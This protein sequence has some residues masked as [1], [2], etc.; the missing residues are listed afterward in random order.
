MA[1]LSK[2]WR[3]KKSPV[4]SADE[5]EELVFNNEPNAQDE[6]VAEEGEREIVSRPADRQDGASTPN[7]GFGGFASCHSSNDENELPRDLS[8]I[9]FPAG[10]DAVSQVR[11]HISAQKLEVL[12]SVHAL[13]F[14]R[15][16]N[17][18]YAPIRLWLGDVLLEHESMGSFWAC[19]NAY[20]NGHAESDVTLYFHAHH[21]T[22][23]G[24]KN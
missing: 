7:S 17:P 21:L 3:S 20:S 1:R 18:Q 22:K 19:I 13:A 4:A 16:K 11:R 15:Q 14:K 8:G 24:K 10:P 9:I 5:E 23:K 6:D 2:L 12:G